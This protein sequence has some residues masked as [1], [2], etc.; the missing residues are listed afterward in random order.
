MGSEEAGKEQADLEA[1]L[2]VLRSAD[3]RFLDAEAY[4]ACC[5]ALEE[6]VRLLG[7]RIDLMQLFEYMINELYVLFLSCRDALVDAQE[8]QVLRRTA[9]VILDQ[10]MTRFGQ[11]LEE[12]IAD[13]LARLEGIQEAAMERLD[14]RAGETDADLRMIEKLLSSSSFVSLEEE[15]EEARETADRQWVE[16]QT[17]RFISELDESFDSLSKPVIR[18]VMAGLLAQLPM[19]YGSKEEFREYVEGSLTSCTDFAEREACMERLQANVI[20]QE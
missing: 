6:G 12:T 4:A 19:L 20:D 7:V 14:F 10:F 17:E 18:A 15:R 8:E 5:G 3:Y 11:P 13:D 1:A 9:A 2:S 16:E